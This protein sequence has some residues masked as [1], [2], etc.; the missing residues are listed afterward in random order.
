MDIEDSQLTSNI[1]AK[2]KD[3]REYGI[4]P[5]PRIYFGPTKIEKLGI[6]IIDAYGRIYNN[7]YGD[8][9]I[10]LL[11]ESIYDGK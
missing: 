1:L 4:K 3:N 2:L 11:V 9:S 10:E 5:I 7:N 8:Y 6:S